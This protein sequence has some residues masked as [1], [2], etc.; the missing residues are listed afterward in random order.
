MATYAELAEHG[1]AGSAD[2]L[3]VP[4]GPE[5][6]P[7]ERE[8]LRAAFIEALDNAHQTHPCPALGDQLWS[9]CVHYD[10][11]GRMLGVGVCHEER[12]ADAVLA[13]RDVELDRLRSR[14]TELESERHVT[15]E[16][17]SEA[18]EALRADR[19][20]TAELEASPLAWAEKLDPKSL[21]NFL[22]VLGSAAER[23]PMDTALAWVNEVISSFRVAVESQAPREDEP[24][25][26]CRCGEPDVDPYQ[27][28]SDDCTHEFSELNPLGGGS[29]PVE[30]WDAKVSKTC[31][32]G[33]RTSVWHVDDGSAEEE[34][35]GHV[36][37]EHGGVY[38]EAGGSS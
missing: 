7:S 13:V 31:G 34:L 1:I 8:R 21:D 16:A 17:L 33:W 30:G 4:V 19:D 25:S 12:R 3:P 38:P 15:N 2:V 28:E 26:K 20:R 5:P 35:H 10:E 14:I 23:E 27:C 36:V 11:A 29:G 32:C 22:T 18:A 6:Q 37:R 9:G 24:A